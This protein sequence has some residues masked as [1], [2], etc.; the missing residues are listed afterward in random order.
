MASQDKLAFIIP[1]L[2]WGGAE[3]QLIKQ[4]R[5]LKDN[6]YDAHLIVLGDQLDLIKE[7]DIDNRHILLLKVSNSNFLN[8]S[9]VLKSL[10]ASLSILKF[11][12]SRKINV[13]IGVLPL[14]HWVSRLTV[15]IGR[16][17]FYRIKLFQYHKSEQFRANPKNTTA[18][19]I[20]HRLNSMLAWF[21]D[22]GSIFISRAVFEDIS[23]AQFVRRPEI[24]YNFVEEKSIDERYA[25]EY[26]Q[27][28]NKSFKTLLLIPGRLHPVK[29]QLF[30]LEA[31]RSYLTPARM[32]ESKILLIMAGGGAE[33]DSIMKLTKKMGI[34]DHVVI[35]GFVENNLL[36]SFMKLADLVIIPSL[37]EGL[38]NVAIEGIMLKKK[39]LASDAGGLREILGDCNCGKLFRAG[40]AVDL[41]QKFIEAMEGRLLFD[42]DAGYAWYKM[43]FTPEIHI[44]NLIRVL[45]S[46]D[47]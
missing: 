32:D 15:I 4:F 45:K 35:T 36:L 38:G 20:Y 47:K 11:L 44:Q 31:N 3:L 40:N 43:K 18:K 29:G 21:C 30:F 7:V 10:L 39:I 34:A 5:L 14:A 37:F 22:Y 25:R 8:Q 2:T 46:V 41:Q 42:T 24:V 13:V 19:R 28:R 6:G 23:K 12:R 16:V 9:G 1:S 26:L 27:T 17:V 33:E